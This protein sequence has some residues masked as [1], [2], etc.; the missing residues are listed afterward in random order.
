MENGN[1]TSCP[2]LDGSDC[3]NTDLNCDV[4]CVPTGLNCLNTGLNCMGCD[5]VEL[6]CESLGLCYVCRNY[7]CEKEM[8]PIEF[9]CKH[10]VYCFRC[11]NDCDRTIY[12]MCP[13][14][15]CCS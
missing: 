4:V 9:L 1:Y 12:D 7:V 6:G 5:V 14:C 13:I 3:L 11:Y 8:K 10:L 15:C 2:D